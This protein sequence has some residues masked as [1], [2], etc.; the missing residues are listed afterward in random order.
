MIL[1]METKKD[2]L[3]KKRR[4]TEILKNK[5][6]KSLTFKL[7]YR[8]IKTNEQTKLDQITRYSKDLGE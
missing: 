7:I 5:G 3:R 4:S 8:Y 1:R 2:T 6:T